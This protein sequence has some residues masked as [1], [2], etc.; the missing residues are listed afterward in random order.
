MALARG[1]FGYRRIWQLLLCIGL[2][3]NARRVHCIYYLNY[4]SGKRRRRR[5][6]W[7]LSGCCLSPR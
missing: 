1:R 7:R 6:V 4:L 5:K 3:V 2:C